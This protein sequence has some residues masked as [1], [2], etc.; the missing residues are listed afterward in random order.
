M[1]TTIWAGLTMGAIYTLVAVGFNI[2]LVM[3]GVLNFAQGQ[4]MVVGAFVGF[5]GI[6]QE[7]L[8][9]ALVAVLAM[10]AGGVLAVIE[11]R[12]AVRPVAG[13]GVHTELITTLGFAA[14]L[15]GIALAVWGTEPL[16]VP[17]LPGDDTWEVLGGR[18]RPNELLLIGIAVVAAVGFHLWNHRTSAGLA[19]L[20]RTENAEAAT[21]RGINVRRLSTVGFVIAGAFGGL[22][23]VFVAQKTY[24][25]FDIGT[26]FALKGFAAMAVGG[27][28]SQYGALAG[29]LAIGVVEALGARYVEI[30]RAHV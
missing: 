28:G 5:W 23:G 1:M 18:V 29:G 15:S 7:N 25:V 6:S 16:R 2:T 3:S 4:F 27:V 26:V 21:L 9:V 30:G 11:E 19:G 24:A 12:V 10:A 8:P 22:V 20:A 13:R 17:V 14:V